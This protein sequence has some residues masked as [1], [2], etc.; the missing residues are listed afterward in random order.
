MS[1]VF[2]LKIPDV[3]PASV[4]GIF[5]GGCISFSILQWIPAHCGVIGNEAADHL[6]KQDMGILQAEPNPIPYHTAATNVHHKK[7]LEEDVKDA[8]ER[9]QIFHTKMAQEHSHFSD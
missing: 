9:Y 3:L 7:K 5:R 1:H 2:R 6:A 8:V 4:A